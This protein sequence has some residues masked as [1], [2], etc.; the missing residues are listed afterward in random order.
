MSET[1]E[2]KPTQN[3]FIELNV[4]EIEES[5]KKDGKYEKDGIMLR[6][7]EGEEN[8]NHYITQINRENL[9]FGGVL[10][11]NFKRE[12]YGF[13]DYANGDKFF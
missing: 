8:S 5:I 6:K 2:M 1:K 11:D 12:G 4:F 10:N 7:W 9:A 13:N 3:D